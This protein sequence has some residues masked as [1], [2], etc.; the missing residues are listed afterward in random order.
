MYKNS[1]QKDKILKILNAQT[2]NKWKCSCSADQI[3]EKGFPT[4][5]FDLEKGGKG[6]YQYTKKDKNSLATVM[7]F[8]ILQVFLPS[9]KQYQCNFKVTDSTG[10][11][12]HLMFTNEVKNISKKGTSSK[13]AKTTFKKSMR[14]NLYISIKD[15][16]EHVFIDSKFK[17]IDNIAIVE[18][19]NSS[20]LDV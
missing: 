11:K 17:S 16:F 14:H 1:F 12:R 7:P 13:S 8:V 2:M 18:L 6:I 20:N 19:K 15:F 5:T 9:G 4:Y 3:D 10:V